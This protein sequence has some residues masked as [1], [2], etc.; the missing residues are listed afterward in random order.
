VA[1]SRRGFILSSFLLPFFLLLVF[2]SIF[3]PSFISFFWSSSFRGDNI[4]VGQVDR[5][6]SCHGV[7]SCNGSFSLRNMERLFDILSSR[8]YLHFV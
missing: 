5:P 2:M 3:F 7:G 4:L 6:L 1:C 8:L